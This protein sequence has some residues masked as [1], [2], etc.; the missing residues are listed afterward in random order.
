MPSHG[1]K[2]YG[3][4]SRSGYTPRLQ[5]QP[6]I[7]ERREGNRLI[8]LSHI[9]VSL[10]LSEINKCILRQGFKK[11]AR[12]LEMDWGSDTGSPSGTLDMPFELSKPCIFHVCRD[13]ASIPQGSWEGWVRWYTH[14]THFQDWSMRSIQP[15]F[16][17]ITVIVTNRSSRR[18][19]WVTLLVLWGGSSDGPRCWWTF[20]NRGCVG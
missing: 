10:S 15:S 12:T 13:A 6:P 9:N 5:V 14:S 19:G 2:G 1:H 3:V 4:N 8:F 18:V 20:L 16:P 17:V 11:R 7:G